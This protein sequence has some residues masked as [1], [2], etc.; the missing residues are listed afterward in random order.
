MERPEE[1]KVAMRIGIDARSQARRLAGIGYYLQEMLKRFLEAED[2]NEYYLYSNQD[3]E[4]PF[5][6]M[7]R[8]R[9][10]IY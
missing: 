10:R 2:E 7:G 5:N 4:L 8:V 6:T 3:F 1:G 9:K